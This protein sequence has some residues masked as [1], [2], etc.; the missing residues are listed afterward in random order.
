M[1]NAMFKTNGNSGFVL[2]PK[3]L[4]VTI[5]RC[6]IVTLKILE[7][8]HLFTVKHHNDNFMTPH[9]HVELHGARETCDVTWD[10]QREAKRQNLNSFHAVWDAEFDGK[11]KVVLNRDLAF[12]KFTL[13][14]VLSNMFLF[15]SRK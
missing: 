14:E 12:L 13:L 3:G 11:A 10:T 1:N 2:K 9:I 4:E 5:D 15:S 8:R 7:A 6:C